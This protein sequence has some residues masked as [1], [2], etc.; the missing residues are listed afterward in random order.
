MPHGWVRAWKP[1]VPGVHEVF[2]ARAVEHAYPR[3]TRDPW[4]L[5]IVDEGAIRYDL[6]SRHRGAAGGPDGEPAAQMA[7]GVGFHDQA[8]LTRHFK[9]TVGTTPAR[10]VSRA[11]LGA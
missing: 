9:R 2:H 6:E 7:T 4:T 5:F 11:P 1:G 10:Y 3:H 8:H